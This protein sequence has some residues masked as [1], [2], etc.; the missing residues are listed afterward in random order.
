MGRTHLSL[1]TSHRD[2][3]EAA[4]VLQT[5]LGAALGDL[6]LLHRL[7]LF[8]LRGVNCLFCYLISDDP[9]DDWSSLRGK[10]LE[11]ATLTFGVWD[12]TLPARARDPWTLPM[13]NG[14]RWRRF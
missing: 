9:V 14:G 4:S 6:L 5:L 7:D 2:V 13:M 12:L 3:D 11:D 1:S 8:R 10:R